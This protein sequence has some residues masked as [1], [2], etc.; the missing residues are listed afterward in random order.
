MVVS[1]GTDNISLLLFNTDFFAD[2]KLFLVYTNSLYFSCNILYSFNNLLYFL[3]SLLFSSIFSSSSSSSFG[4]FCSFLLSSF[5]SSR[6]SIWLLL[7][8]VL[9]LYTLNNWL[10]KKKKLSLKW[11]K[12]TIEIKNINSSKS[13]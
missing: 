9:A 7:S 8:S 11:L 10:I 5:S 6:E 13:W 2:D 1:P 12:L 3:L 4:S